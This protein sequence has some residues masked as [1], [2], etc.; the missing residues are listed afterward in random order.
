MTWLSKYLW[1]LAI[2]CLPEGLWAGAP[3]QEIRRAVPV[4]DA[5]RT[6]SR[7]LPDLHVGDGGSELSRTIGDVEESF[8]T[9][10]LRPRSA[11][12]V[13]TGPEPWLTR[14]R[15]GI[16]M[17]GPLLLDDDFTLETV[18]LY[19]RHFPDDPIILSTWESEDSA[20]LRACESAGAVL[21]VNCDPSNAGPANINRQIVSTRAGLAK[22]AELG[23][24][25]VIK[26]RTDQRFYSPSALS[27]LHSLLSVF[28]LQAD[29][30]QRARIIGVSLNT[31]KYRRYGLSDMF[32][33]GTLDDL[34]RY[35]SC[36]LDARSE[37]PPAAFGPHAE[38][39]LCEVYLEANYLESLG[40]A[41]AWTVADSW[42]AFADHFCVIDPSAIDL[43][44]PKYASHREYR[45]LSYGAPHT[46]QE[47]SFAD[48]MILYNR[49]WEPSPLVEAACQLD[50]DT[51]L[52]ARLAGS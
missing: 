38:L 22:C 36:E 6:L 4:R 15:T 42:K 49:S 27:F 3:W 8:A 45:R 11:Q 44:W 25:H 29:L 18:R 9:F 24:G 7:R 21:V 23:V 16:I 13:G 46:G 26:T 47:L 20:A 14:P 34:A 12:A 31:L 40:R 10:H 1:R 50:W 39:R 19:R 5:L 37:A 30:P 33:F 51:P 52:P 43:F 2:R 41:L 17:Q 32:L 35:W 48:W 28:P